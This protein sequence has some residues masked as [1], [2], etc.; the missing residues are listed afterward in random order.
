[1]AYAGADDEAQ[2]LFGYDRA[3]SLSPSL[4]LHSLEQT[5]TRVCVSKALIRFRGYP[6]P[7]PSPKSSL[8]TDLSSIK[9]QINFFFPFF[10]KKP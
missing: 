4:P 9:D 2:K 1:M 10:S 6:S 3:L 8:K 5:L 7:K